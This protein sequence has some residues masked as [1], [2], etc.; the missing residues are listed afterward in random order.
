MYAPC[1]AYQTF[2]SW[3][4]ALALKRRNYRSI[5][6][7]PPFCYPINRVVSG[8]MLI[9]D[10]ITS[11]LPWFPLSSPPPW[12]LPC[13]LQLNQGTR[14]VL[15]LNRWSLNFC[16]LPGL[17]SRGA[18]QYYQL[19]DQLKGPRVS[20]VIPCF[21]MLP[22]LVLNL[23]MTTG[24]KSLEKFIFWADF[25]RESQYWTRTWTVDGCSDHDKPNQGV[26]CVS[27]WAEASPNPP[28]Y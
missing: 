24:G 10:L 5:Q 28:Q 27:I 19:D 7:R 12:F 16:L 13:S 8:K 3:N 15:H 18:F 21:V 20:S 14:A 2:R 26:H 4:S 23:P 6:I 17:G 1:A 11:I 22:I 9:E 25:W